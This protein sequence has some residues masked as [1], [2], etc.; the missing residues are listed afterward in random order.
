MRVGHRKRIETHFIIVACRPAVCV[1]Q[2]D[3]QL[4]NKPL[5]AHFSSPFAAVLVLWQIVRG[6]ECG[7][8]DD[9]VFVAA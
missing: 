8:C 1:G 2:S 9:V 6:S 3:S 7:C 5:T 4:A